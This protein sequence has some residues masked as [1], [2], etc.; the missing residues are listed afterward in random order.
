MAPDPPDLTDP[1][2]LPDLT[3][4]DASRLA[5]DLRVR[6][7]VQ[8][9][10]FRPFVYRLA[11]QHG[12]YGWV[13]NDPG[14]VS[15]RLEGTATALAAFQQ[16]LRA[17]PP[18]AAVLEH[19][20]VQDAVPQGY[21]DFQI[22]D[23]QAGGRTTTRVSPDLAP[24][25]ACLRELRDPGDRR[26]RYPYIN[27]TDCGP[28]HS[29]V[30]SLPYDRPATT[31]RGWPLCADCQREYDDPLDRRYH[32]QPLA[33]PACGPDYVL[34]GGAAP[35]RGWEA[36][37]A[38]AQRLAAGEILAVKGVGGYHLM[39]DAECEDSVQGL[40]E[41]K[42][43]REKP[44]ALLARDL[45]TANSVVELT[46]ADRE[47]LASPGRPIV[48]GRS[49]RTLPQVAPLPGLLG[50]MLP[51]SPLHELLF[52]AGAPPLLVATSG[53]RSSEPMVT[54]DQ[55][56]LAG[57]GELADA[58]LLGERLI[59]ARVDDS[60]TTSSGL[61]GLLIRRGRGLAPGVT[62][63]LGG[64]SGLPP[65]LGVGADLK[66]S[67]SLL[68]DGQVMTSAYLGNLDHLACRAAHQRAVGD[69][70]ALYGLRPE[71]CLIAHDLHP[72]YAS[73]QM[74]LEWPA[75]E[76]VAVQHHHAHLASVLAEHGEEDAALGLILDGSG[77]SED[78]GVWGGELLIGSLG[79]GF[80]RA[81]SLWPAPLPGGDAAARFPVQAAVGYL[82][83]AGLPLPQGFPALA[84]RAAQLIPT[85]LTTSSCGRLFDA[86][87]ALLGFHTEQSY[88]GQAGAWLQSL[89]GTVP[90]PG[91]APLPVI[92]NGSRL[93]WRPALHRLAAGGA[94]AAELA[95][96]FHLGLVQGLTDAAAA[97]CGAHGLKKVA[98][99]GGVWQNSL[100][101]QLF[102][103]RLRP[104]GLTLLTNRAVP[105]NDE[106]LSLGQV[107]VAWAL[108]GQIL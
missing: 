95:L 64:D 22:L 29:I 16:A 89:A 57:L 92:W 87:A 88:E 7:V 66:N 46:A 55:E 27:C 101:L 93:D 80:T 13:R 51:S 34:H 76:H 74:A 11:R 90:P 84:R 3:A 94:P 21:A 33:C 15:I 12:L 73:T 41:R 35:L 108:I 60:V 78:G 52:D 47:L 62:A 106:G 25:A 107:A 19:V 6:G 2:D 39:C 71:D 23:S 10:G 43:R 99:S 40:R 67:V 61:G 30:L 59:A 38:A 104:H 44:F 70:L 77:Y 1:P 5:W 31:M 105:C 96:G 102:A 86:A 53:N 28:R 56:A 72:G 37:T 8:G 20:G 98:V 49:R 48:L 17:E 26:Y 103:A 65:I 9:V 24:C 68:I 18:P 81:G 69:L 79:Q 100:L 50:V 32:A 63:R 45:E 85:A 97:L 42:Y 58:L 4:P 83:A 54:D 14:G 75:L 91:V 82:H 36:I